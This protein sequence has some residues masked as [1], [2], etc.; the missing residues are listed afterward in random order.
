MR[1]RERERDRH[2][3]CVCG[4]KTCVQRESVCVRECMC[5]EIVCV[6][7]WDAVVQHVITSCYP[8]LQMGDRELMCA[9]FQEKCV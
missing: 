1:E 4:W 9:Y 5:E 8:I 2:S 3:A 7:I 6:I